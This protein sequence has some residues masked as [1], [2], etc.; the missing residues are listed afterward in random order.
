[1]L[2]AVPGRGDAAAP[3][4]MVASVPLR[5]P[6]IDAAHHDERDRAGAAQKSS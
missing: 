3:R 2:D 5:G 1:V 4:P 6:G